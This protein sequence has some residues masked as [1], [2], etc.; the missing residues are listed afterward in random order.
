MTRAKALTVFLVLALALSG[1]FLTSAFAQVV[2]RALPA[3]RP[4]ASPTPSPSAL[5]APALGV[6]TRALPP[7]PP[8]PSGSSNLRRIKSA[9]DACIVFAFNANCGETSNVNENFV[10]GATIAW[11]TANL[12]T[13]GKHQDFVLVPGNAGAPLAVSAAGGYTGATGPN[14]SQT[15]VVNG[16]YVF[17]SLNLTTNV[18]DAI[19]Y[20]LVGSAVSIETYT[21]GTLSVKT[22]T[23]T[24]NASGA[25]SV[26]I[27]TKGLTPQ[28]AYTVGVEDQLTGKCVFTSPSSSQTTTPSTLC[29]LNT[30]T[31]TGTNPNAN[32]LL[33]AN[34]GVA[35]ATAPALPQG[36]TYVATVF[37]QTTG[38]RVASRLFSVIDG[39]ATAS[40]AR[41]NLQF[42]NGTAT[43]SGASVT[44]I[45]WNGTATA[46]NDPGQTFINLLFGATGMP[47]NNN[48]APGNDTYNLVISDP[49]GTEA[50]LAQTQTVNGGTTI[51]PGN[52]QFGLR[53]Q[54]VPFEQAYPGSTWTATI[55]DT[56]ASKLVAEQSFQ[57][58][59]YSASVLFQNPSSASVNMPTGGSV[60]TSIQF[61]NTADS[62]FG[63]N[64][65]DPLTKFVT[66]T[67]NTNNKLSNVTLQAPGATTVCTPT[68]TVPCNGTYSDT[69]GNTWAVALS[70]TGGATPDFTFTITPSG[71]TTALAVGQSI[72]VTG[73]TFT[74]ASCATAPGCEFITSLTAQDMIA[75][76]SSFASINQSGVTNPINITEGTVTVSA[77]DSATVIGYYDSTNTFHLNQDAGYTPRFNQA[78]MTQNQPF[79]SAA[80]KVELAFTVNNTSTNQIN[81]FD[82]AM[83][84]A[85]NQSSVA[86]DTTRTPNGA[87]VTTIGSCDGLVRNTI[88][89]IPSTPIAGHSSQTYYLS[90]TPASTSFSY[91]DIVG[92]IILAAPSFQNNP[93]AIAPASTSVQTFIG[94]PTKIDSTAIAAYSLNGGLMTGGLTPGSIGTSTSNTLTYNLHNTPTSSDPFPDEVDFV[95]LQ[96]PSQTFVTVPASCSS[97]TVTTN[98]WSCLTTTS[99][100]GVTTYYFG[101]CSQQISPTPTLPASSTSFG[102]DLLTV[103]PF[104]APNEPFSLTP[105]SVLSVNIPVTAGATQ[106]TT[107]IT[108]SSWAHGATTDAW[109][110]PVTSTLSV[111]PLATAGVGFS[112]ISAPGGG[113]AAVAQGTQPQ[114]VG[115]YVAGTPNTNTYIYKIKNT[116]SIAITSATIGVPGETTTGANGADASGNIWKLTVAPTLTIEQTGTANGCTATFQNPA[117]GTDQ[118][119][120]ITISC[121]GTDFPAGDTLDVQFTALAPLLINSSYN[122]PATIN[123][124]GA[125]VSPNWFEDTQILV[126]LSASVSIAVNGAASCPTVVLTPATSTVNFGT[127]ATST[128]VAC[129]DAMIATVTTD[130]ASPSNWSLYVSADANPARTGA[131]ATNELLIETDSAKSTSAA[132]IPCP[133]S[134]TPPCMA[135]D[136]TAAYT[137][138]GLTSSG[139][140][141]RLAFTEAGGTGVNNS[142]VKIFV[143]FEVSIGTETVPATGHQQTI[144]YTWIA[145]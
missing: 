122:F 35:L 106:T 133:T 114:I 6:R 116:S 20:V 46:A 72:S 135:Y 56:T 53:T 7:L 139:T 33:I 19:A 118:T 34:W 120:N 30:A 31:L 38:Q 115:N 126:A 48:A 29:L 87:T 70:T 83:P 17:A 32:G 40:T 101:Q 97:L 58:L 128:T 140:G 137:P 22:Q 59:G 4:V 94:T 8:M 112:S 131:G 45:A 109:S 76:Y 123:G 54:A 26:T 130:A 88:C 143:N 25:T 84:A 127:I 145:N 136:N 61:T 10:A 138:I 9:T 55:Y 89:V 14:E 85:F 105:G 75:G 119:G 2:Q 92:T 71:T 47:L 80:S 132:G 107:P 104:A 93:V 23:F 134:V 78:T 142:S 69:A 74:G 67:V 129:P 124:S 42:T 144:T 121:P 100:A 64:N 110:T 108:I 28:H 15:G 52:N 102:S 27:A 24:T 117:S 36:G 86:V 39:R 62:T 5:P 44:R 96:I 49:T 79:T 68:T 60:T 11:N 73:I 50:Y 125:N 81:D 1:A 103:C 37:D 43:S 12:P 3:A 113:N 111:S 63:A 91:T 51:T 57:I 95:A 65:G 90:F 77:T 98:G 13:T 16:I 141:T 21:D 18:W 82:I 41:V 99:V 66:S